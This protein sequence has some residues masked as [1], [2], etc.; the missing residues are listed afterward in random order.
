MK[1]KLIIIIPILLIAGVVIFNILK[2]MM[3]K[4]EISSTIDKSIMSLYESEEANLYNIS[5]VEYKIKSFEKQKAFLTK[6]KWYR[7]EVELKC[8]AAINLS[9]EEK[10]RVSDILEGLLADFGMSGYKTKFG[11]V[12]T[13]VDLGTRNFLITTIVN[14]ETIKYVEY[15]YQRSYE[16]KNFKNTSGRELDAWNCATDAVEK[17][18][19]NYTNIKVSSYGNSKVSYTSNTGIYTIKGTVSYTNAYGATVNNKFTCNL[20]LTEK[21]YKNASTVIY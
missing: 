16:I 4:R 2:E 15:G 1:K 21:G 10:Q 6:D 17:E 14:N 12:V 7:I 8:D 11:A 20:E 19:Y 9:A 18:L 5:N 13:N 3:I